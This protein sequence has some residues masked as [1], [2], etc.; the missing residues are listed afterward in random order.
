[1]WI[2]IGKQVTVEEFEWMCNRRGFDYPMRAYLIDMMTHVGLGKD[3]S[4][5][6]I[7]GYEQ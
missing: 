4:Y 7:P 3:L 5:E 2:Q 6:L 1:M